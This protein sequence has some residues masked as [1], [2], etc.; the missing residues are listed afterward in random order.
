MLRIGPCLQFGHWLNFV[1]I[2]P[3]KGVKTIKLY[4]LDE[5]SKNETSQQIDFLA[6]SSQYCS[7][8]ASVYRI[9]VHVKIIKYMITLWKFLIQLH[10]LRLGM[11]RVSLLRG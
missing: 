7:S 11:I 4:K 2:P 10:V 5:H 8:T 3:P 6:S 9:P 1:A